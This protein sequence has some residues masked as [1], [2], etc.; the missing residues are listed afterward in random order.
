ML[1]RATASKDVARIGLF[2]G[3]PGRILVDV[4][5]LGHPQY[6]DMAK[7]VQRVED[8]GMKLSVISPEDLAIHKLV[9]A[10]DKDV[11]DLERLL[12]V[13]RELDF[14]YVRTWLEKMVPPGDRRLA[15]LADLE[16][17]SA[18]SRG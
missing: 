2:K 10:R 8:D 6:E 7:R 13:R 11:T 17:R 16:R 3:R 5:M 15:V 12:A 18:P 14:H 1:D 9:F 4:F